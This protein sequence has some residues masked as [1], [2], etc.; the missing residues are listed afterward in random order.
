VLVPL[1][2][3]E[4]ERIYTGFEPGL[5]GKVFDRTGVFDT[6]AFEIVDSVA[7]VILSATYA[8]AER[9]SGGTYHDTLRVTLSEPV[10]GV[11]DEPFVFFG[12]SS[13]PTLTGV[14]TEG[15]VV[16]ALIPV[17]STVKTA[18]VETGDMIAIRV[19]GA[20]GISDLNGAVQDNPQNRR[21]PITVTAPRT[22]SLHYGPTL[23]RPGT[24]MFRIVLGPGERMASPDPD[25][26]ATITMFDRTGNVV[27]RRNFKRNSD[28]LEF[29]WNGTNGNGRLVGQA[30]YI[31][32]LS[33]EMNGVKEEK[34]IKIGVKRE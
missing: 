19:S 2:R 34:K 22:F 27:L 10:R 17:S 1:G 32:I 30:T 9:E 33:I 31:A 16:T 3:G 28:N 20:T 4:F 15:S 26:R 13:Q 11:G 23:F 12:P 18:P 14:T 24:G 8:V 29:V 6:A 25:A 5:F 21:V 7:P